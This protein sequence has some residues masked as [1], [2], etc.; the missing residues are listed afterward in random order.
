[1]Q[2][3]PLFA[4][5]WIFGL[6]T[7]HLATLNRPLV[8]GV[9]ERKDSMEILKLRFESLQHLSL[10][11]GGSPSKTR[12]VYICV[13]SHSQGLSFKHT[14]S[15]RYSRVYENFMKTIEIVVAAQIY[16]T[17]IKRVSIRVARWFVF[18]PKIPNLGKF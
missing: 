18:K 3:P 11:K 8:D 17:K 4:Q 6:K 13:F 10:V 5:I 16:M 7:N 12:N 2:D 1:V 14:P 15:Q 9:G